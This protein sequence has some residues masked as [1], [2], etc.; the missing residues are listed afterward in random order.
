MC[1]AIEYTIMN[2]DMC[3][4]VTRDTGYLEII[5]GPM[6]SG[7][8]S[9]LLEIYKQY[10]YCNV[11]TLVINHSMDT[12]YHETKMSTHNKEMIPCKQCNTLY[13]LLEP[14]CESDDPPMNLD[15]C[16]VVLINEAQF[17]PD[18]LDFVTM[19]LAKGKRVYLCGLDGDYKRQKF[20]TILD[21]IP[22]CDKVTKLKSLCGICK[23][24]T[25][26]IFSMRMCEDTQQTLIGSDNYV[27]VCRMCYC[28][29]SSKD[30]YQERTSD[31]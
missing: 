10:E 28:T 7:K 21:L 15:S 16:S 11:A 25:C 29:H 17:F 2:M 3:S 12:R 6:F 20:G 9:K 30:E 27:P 5:L 8:T 14:S 23:N 22:L 4:V 13:S 26:A 1:I 31:P 19:L 24:G 18:L